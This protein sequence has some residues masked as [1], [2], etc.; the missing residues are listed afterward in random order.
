MN[1]TELTGLATRPCSKCGDLQEQMSYG[2]MCRNCKRTAGKKGGDARGAQ[3][4]KEAAHRWL[5]ARKERG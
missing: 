1:P 5:D 3:K 4:R 2:W